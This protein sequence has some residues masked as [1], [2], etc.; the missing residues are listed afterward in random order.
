MNRKF[1]DGWPLRA[2]AL[3]ALLSLLG[4]GL[5]PRSANAQR[6]AETS[7]QRPQTVFTNPAMIT[8]NDADV[9]TPYP[10]T[11]TVSGL[12]GNIPNTPGSIKVTLNNFTH[13]FPD[14]VGIVLV[15]PTGLGFLLQDGAGDDPDVSTTYTLS[16]DGADFLP[17]DLAW[18]PGTYKPTAYFSTDVFPAPGPGAV[19]DIPG[20]ID[21]SA[22]FASVFGGTNPNGVWSL[23]VVD[24]V[25]E[26][27]GFITGGWSLEINTSGGGASRRA[28]L[29]FDGDNKTDYAVVR[30]SGGTLNWYEQRSTAGPAFQAWGTSGDKLVD[31]DYDGD[32]KCDVA[33]WRNGVFYIL[34]SSDGTF[35]TIQFGQSGDFPGV[36]QDF[37]GDGKADPTVTRNNGSHWVWY[38]QRSTAGFNAVTFGY[39]ATDIPVRGDFDGD[40]KADIAV[41]RTN[42]G[43]GPPNT[44]FV[45]R[46]SD[47]GVSAQSFGNFNTEFIVP[48]DYD[49]DGKTD[50][51]IYRGLFA[52][53][54]GGGVWYLVNSSDGSFHFLTFGQ[55]GVD[56][57]AVGDYDGDGKDDPAVWRPGA[58]GVFYVNRSTAGFTAFPF[59]TSG[60]TIPAYKHF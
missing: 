17:D 34:K 43:G 31:A 8:I 5:L 26:D 18:G 24:F 42:I 30:N 50:Y 55:A 16:D 23:Y 3:L 51:A 21:G 38:M 37:D 9:S 25:E 19:Y 7:A 44:F 48:A 36:T 10:S 52:S 6:Q 57:P 45:L 53:G 22:T 41:Y 47:G 58:P 11:I 27:G 33:V 12:T 60:D 39:S 29:D 20:P 15:G 56:V 54:F 35:S 1:F 46:S 49:G 32:Q 40:H 59:G 2:F 28:T 13:T 4:Y 14:D